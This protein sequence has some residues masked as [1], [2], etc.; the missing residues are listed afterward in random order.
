MVVRPL[1]LGRRLPDLPDVGRQPRKARAVRG[2]RRPHLPRRLHPQGQDADVQPRGGRAVR[3]QF[4]AREEERDRS[5]SVGAGLA[6]GQRGGWRCLQGRELEAG[7]RDHPRALRQLEERPAAEDQARHRARRALAGH[8]PRHAGARRRRPLDR[9]P[10]ERLRPD[11]QGGQAQGRGRADPE[12][13]LVRRAQHL[14]PAV[15][16]REAPAGDRLGDALRADPVER[17]LRPR[18][19]DVRRRRRS[20]SRSGRRRSPIAPTSTRRRR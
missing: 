5:R 4:G 10:A 9:L 14:A 1:G 18:Q 2:G 6:Q 15:R 11:D 20:S 17:V 16:Q 13:A 19:A 8:A 7:Q 12:R 3:H